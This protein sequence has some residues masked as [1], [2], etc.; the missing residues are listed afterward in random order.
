M[1]MQLNP[2]AM[3][4]VVQYVSAAQGGVDYS[5]RYGAR[6]PACGQRTRIYRT[7]PWD[8]DLRVRYHKCEHQGCIVNALGTSIKSI[9][10]DRG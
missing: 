6:C 3:A 10:V 4:L 8:G 2:A 1:T 7:M 9:E 5:A